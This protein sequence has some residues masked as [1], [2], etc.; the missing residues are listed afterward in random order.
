[1]KFSKMKFKKIE[2]RKLKRKKIAILSILFGIIA[3]IF[4]K[5]IGKEI[6]DLLDKYDSAMFDEE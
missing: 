1:M 3:C 2:L 5:T 4:A 6:N